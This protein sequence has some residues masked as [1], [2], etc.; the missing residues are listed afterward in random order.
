MAGSFRIA[1]GYVEVTADESS[2]NR[3]MARLQGKRLSVGI[4]PQMDDAAFQRVTKAL[5]RLTKDR[6]VRILASADTRVAADEIRNLTNRRRVRIGVDVDTRVAADDLA[7]LTRRRTSRVVAEANTT[8]A[9]GRLDL[10][11][12]DRRMNLHV[13][14]DRS[15]LSSLSSLGGAGGGLGG[16]TSGIT[17][18]VSAAIGALPTLASLGQSIIAMG[19]AAA[20]AAPAVLSLGAAFAAV[21]IGTSGIGDAFKAAFAP[22]VT[23]GAAAESATRRV[24]SAARSLAK[25][26]QGVKDA[27]VA[28][29]AARVKA[30]RDIKDAQLNLKNTVQDVAD[31][32][33]RAAE[34]VA[35]AE[36]DLTDAQKAAKQAQLDLTAARKDAAEQLVD[37]NNQMADSEL[38]HREAVLRV[39][40]AQADLAKTLADPT[41]SQQQRDEAQLTYDQAVQHLKEQEIAQQRLKDKTDA[42]NKAGVEGSDEVVKAKQGIVDADQAAADKAQALAD[43]EIEASRT[44]VDGAQRVAKAERDVADARAAAAKAAVDGARSIADAQASVADA[45]RS[46]A[47]AQTSGAAATNKLADAMA[48]LSPNARAFVDAVVAQA[49]AW[50]A[51]KLDVQDRLFAGLGQ[52]FTTMTTAVLPSLRTGLTGT[53]GILN[54]MALKAADAVT[55]LGKTGMLRKLFDG[56]N[57]GLKPLSKI[58]AQFLKGLAQI[59]IAASPAF[60]RLTTA[61]GGAATRIADKLDKAFKSGAMTKAIDGAIGIAKQFGHLLGDVFGTLNN[62]FKAAGKGGGDALGTLGAVFKEL[63]RVTALP[64]VQQGLTNIFK[65]VNTIA[66]LLAGAIGQTVIQLVEGFGKIAPAI[67]S[68]FGSL[69]DVGPLLGL[70]LLRA[71]PVLGAL[72]L[73]APILGDL[74]K[75]IAGL[76]KSVA[77]L[78]QQLATFSGGIMKALAPVI[79]SLIGVLSGIFKAVAPIMGKV[80]PMLLQ[81]VKALAGPLAGVINSLIPMLQPILGI[82]TALPMAFLPL[83][84]TIMKLLPPI[85][86]LVVSLLE[87]VTAVLTPML[88]LIQ[89]WAKVLTT[90]LGF[91]ISL[92][93]PVISTVIGWLSKLVDGVTW[94][95]NE[96]VKAFQWLYDTLVGHS[97]IPDLVHAIIGWFTNLWTG[98]KKIFTDLKNWVVDLW[99][100]LWTGVRTRWDAFWTGLRSAVSGAWSSLKNSVSSLRTSLTG[101]WSAMWTSIRDKASAVFT[102]IRGKVTDFKN[103]MKSAFSSLR[104][105]L[106]SIWKGIQS[107]FSA[108]VK[109]V[110]GNVYNDG[111]RKMWNTIA[112]KISSKITL[113]AIKLGFSQGGVVPGTGSGDTVPAMLTPG[114]RVLSTAQVTRLG[115]HG[116]IDALVGGRG[117]QAAVRPSGTGGNPRTEGPLPKFASGGVVGTL[118]DIG[119]SVAGAVGSGLS[120]AKN[121]VVGGLQAAAR[122]AIESLVRPL[123]NSIPGGAGIG[124]L[125]KGLSN[126]ALSGM[127]GWFGGQDKKATG[128]PAVQKALSWARGQAGKPYQWGGGG[129]PSYDCSG[130]MAAI[131]KVIQGKSPIGRLWSTHSFSGNTA[132]AGWVRNLASPF[133]IGVTNAG[134]GHTAGTLAGVNVESRGGAGVIVGKGA[135][136]FNDSLFG[137]HYGFAP[138]TKFDSGGLLQPG[139]TLALNKTRKPEAVFTAEER[140][141]IAAMASRG[142][143]MSVTFGDIVIKDASLA[144]AADRK[145]VVSALLVEIKEGLRTFDRSRSR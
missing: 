42:A 111:I 29:A 98:T 97:I 135:R 12:R 129:D 52:K 87:L 69:K 63:R 25:A 35:S 114:E 138:A 53:A 49:G 26:Q 139:A 32:Q 57:G 141:Q 95:V 5:D 130:F 93:V 64:E 59:G 9:R 108:P 37:L 134:V 36:R 71:N 99:N 22:A 13:D 23:S 66:K 3:S 81:V 70:I 41:A 2:F 58:P 39:Q 43:A 123:I 103:A 143:G 105:A 28:A 76:V 1:E 88:P 46:L 62:I 127:L 38:D 86:E 125:L 107:K 18:L 77:P 44:Q 89:L 55:E 8:E 113:P 54:T 91:A 142:G 101:V 106:G 131:Q 104:D 102:T 132:P 48:R 83:V 17:G 34:S 96:I 82:V 75:P 80:A 90:E 51:L 145:R 19:P 21:K 7:N 117:R 133:Q 109:W 122:K 16:L 15:A 92:L 140:A 121:L 24:E 118:K 14:V 120:W 61:A 10:L 112:S 144:T 50:R 40:D 128:G 85:G 78:L 137:S 31:A 47:D 115:G 124:G 100:R 119:S 6:M 30:A 45:A 72:A 68:A 56:L 136:G 11:S 84:P 110:I 94:I 60:K 79:G 4:T 73:I 27:E 74:A 33:R 65:A 67:T 126:K 116:A 20:I